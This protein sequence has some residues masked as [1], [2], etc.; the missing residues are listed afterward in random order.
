MVC[1]AVFVFL[2]VCRLL[3]AVCS[4]LFGFVV[5]VCCACFVCKLF[6]VC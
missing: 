6:A 3:S 1:G 5:V 2:V 4:S